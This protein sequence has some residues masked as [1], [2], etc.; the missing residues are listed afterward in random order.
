MILIAHRGNTNGPNPDRE[1]SPDYITEAL[2]KGYNVEV[3]VWHDGD[4][5]W[6]GHDKPTY[7]VDESFLTN[8]ML[9]CHA[10][11]Y[12]SLQKMTENPSIHCFWHQTDDY[13]ITSKGH[14]WAYPGQHTGKNTICVM[15]EVS[16]MS[17]PNECLGVCSDFVKD[18][19]S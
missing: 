12:S 6:L 4:N 5:F 14:I 18:H 16:R 1:N 15:P 13:T 11:E 10:K 9:W 7:V 2:D 17:H 3:D 19:T 8:S